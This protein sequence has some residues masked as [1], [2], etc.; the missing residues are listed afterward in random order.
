MLFFSL[1]DHNIRAAG[2]FNSYLSSLPASA[3]SRLESTLDYE[4]EGVEEDLDFI[5]KHMDKKLLQ[6]DQADIKECTTDSEISVYE[7]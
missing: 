4:Y 3:S 6:L 7:K 1:S 5:A 2:D